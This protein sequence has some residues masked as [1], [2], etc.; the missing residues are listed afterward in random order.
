MILPVQEIEVK[1]FCMNGL[2]VDFKIMY[3]FGNRN[4]IKDFRAII[5]VYV[6]TK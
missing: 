3:R 6:P 4:C 2:D 1:N 5:Y